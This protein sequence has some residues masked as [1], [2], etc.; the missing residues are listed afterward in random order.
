MIV[1]VGRVSTDAER[2]EELVRVG[3]ALVAGS[4]QDPGCIR[5]GMFAAT[6]DPNSFVFVEEWESQELLSA[7]FRTQHVADFMTAVPALLTAPPDVAF[8]DIE[9]TR[10]LADA[11]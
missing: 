4:R 10:T 5:Y 6:D 2:R 8:H 7:H 1:V 9:S 11:G 3:E